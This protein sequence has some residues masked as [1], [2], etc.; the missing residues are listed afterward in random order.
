MREEL[1]Q[2][3]RQVRT[4]TSSYKFLDMQV[5]P[6]LLLQSGSIEMC[7]KLFFCGWS[8][9]GWKRLD[10][11]FFF[12]ILQMLFPIW[13]E[14]RRLQMCE[15]VLKIVCHV[16]HSEWSIK[17]HPVHLPQWFHLAGYGWQVCQELFKVS[18]QICKGSQ[19]SRH[20]CVH[21]WSKLLLWSCRVEVCESVQSQL[22]C[23]QSKSS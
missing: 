16:C 12:W 19:L 4:W 23:R 7:Q 22:I 14:T 6:W 3:G 18:W 11:S 1:Q 5:R 15:E 8:Q 13:L 2:G 20:Q 21:L 9:F 17:C 10:E